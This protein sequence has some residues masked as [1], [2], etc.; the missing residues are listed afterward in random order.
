M[1]RDQELRDMNS[2]TMRFGM[3]VVAGLVCHSTALPQP[4]AAAQDA[5]KILLTATLDKLQP[6]FAGAVEH[7]SADGKLRIGPY[8]GK[9]GKEVPP[10]G[11]LAEGLYLG[12]VRGLWKDFHDARL[13]RVQVTEVMDDGTVVA[14]V[15]SGLDGAIPLGKLILLVRPPQV[16][17]AQMR[18]L[19]DLV[20]LEE[21]PLPQAAA[22]EV[23]VDPTP[24]AEATARADRAARNLSAIAKALIGYERVHGCYPPASL[25]GPDGKAWHSWRVLILCYFDEPDLTKLCARYSYE[26]PW[27]GPRNKQL[28]ELMPAV[29]G[30]EPPGKPGDGATRF[31]AVTGAGAMFSSDGV[32]FDP[33]VKPY[34]FGRGTRESA[35]EDSAASTLMVGTLPRDTRIPWTKP[36]DVVVPHEPTPL[37]RKGFFGADY[38]SDTVKAPHAMFVRADGGLAGISAS[39]DPRV[40]RALTTIA[41]HEGIDISTTPGAH[42]LV[43]PHAGGAGGTSSSSQTANRRPMTIVIFTENG[44]A[45]A[46]STQ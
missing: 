1:Q 20:T 2:K 3:A 12:V 19:P 25:I 9:P 15:G 26:E 43:M 29:Y 28:L 46:R 14:K 21:G 38:E 24:D 41:G 45:K 40:F 30:D 5:P 34:R 44:V 39:I 10:N 31:A 7:I 4:R 27:D 17:T 36:E 8:P 22:R 35:V 13:V 33:A 11:P 16:S 32:A 18:A 42:L 23:A 37:G 6:P